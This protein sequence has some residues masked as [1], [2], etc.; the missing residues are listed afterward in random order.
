[1]TKEANLVLLHGYQDSCEEEVLKEQRESLRDQDCVDSAENEG[2]GIQGGRQR[3]K[4]PSILHCQH[5]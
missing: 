5:A 4:G 1:M 3:L 2:E